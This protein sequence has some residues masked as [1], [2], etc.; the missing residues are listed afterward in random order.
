MTRAPIPA[1]HLIHGLDGPVVLVSGRVAARLLRAGLSEYHRQHRGDDPEVDQTIIGM[2]LAALAWRE[3]ISGTDRG[4]TAADTPPR[5]APS[6][7]WL[8]TTATARVVGITARAVVKAIAAGRLPAQWSAGR[9]WI[10]P[11]DVGHYRARRAA[12]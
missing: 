8:T 4:T 5:A 12:A 7:A 11:E 9:W 6:P 2:K 3:R 10:S 1:E